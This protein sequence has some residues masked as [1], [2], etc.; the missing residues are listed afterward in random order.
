[1]D[2]WEEARGVIRGLRE[3]RVGMD[4]FR[5]WIK[6]KENVERATEWRKIRAELMWVELDLNLGKKKLPHEATRWIE[7]PVWSVKYRKEKV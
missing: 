7:L 5:D 1:M 2:G 3:D 4:E 6:E